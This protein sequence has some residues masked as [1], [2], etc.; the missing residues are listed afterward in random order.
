LEVNDLNIGLATA[1]QNTLG[2]ALCTNNPYGRIIKSGDMSLFYCVYHSFLKMKDSNI[3]ENKT[4]EEGSKR[5][6]KKEIEPDTYYYLIQPL[7]SFFNEPDSKLIITSIQT[8]I[9]ILEKNSQF[10]FKFFEFLFDSL[11]IIKENSDQEVRNCANAFDEFIKDALGNP[12]QGMLSNTFVDEGGPFS[13][14]ILLRKIKD[15]DTHPAVAILVVSW[16]TFLE[17]MP[18]IKLVENLPEIITKLF[19]MLRSKIKDVYQCSEQCLKKLSMGIEFHYDELCNTHKDIVLEILNVIRENCKDST[20]K[21]KICALEWLLMFLSKYNSTI[22]QYLD[23][24]KN[25]CKI[26]EKE[27]KDRK[28]LKLMKKIGLL[29][30]NEIKKEI[31]A[32]EKIKHIPFNLFNTVFDVLFVNIVKCSNKQIE[33]LLMKC[34]NTFQELILTTP[35][36]VIKE[37]ISPL[38]QSIKK[39]ISSTL[40][41]SKIILILEWTLKLFKRF[42]TDI[43]KDIE[44]FIS[45]LTNIIP[46]NNDNVFNHLFFIICEIAKTFPQLNKIIIKEIVKKLMVN[47]T[48]I[49]SYGIDI[50]KK[51]SITIPVTELFENIV[52]EIMIYETDTYFLVSMVNLLD[53]FLLLEDEANEVVT[54]LKNYNKKN[55]TQNEKNFYEKIFNLWSYN[56]VSSIILSLLSE[57]FEL[58]FYLSVK[59]FELNLTKEDYI[60]LNQMVQLLESSVWNQIRIK[61]IQPY[62]Y[63]Y[64]IKALSSILMLLPQGNAYKYLSIRI[65]SVEII[66]AL[67]QDENKKENPNLEISKEKMEEIQSFIKIFL[68]RQ[69]KKLK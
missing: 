34:L 11:I 68:K 18:Y 33:T 63:V 47:L 15:P 64:L 37:K 43:F 6:I 4:G 14:K 7:V 45:R 12:F 2:M 13:I 48:I 29:G 69:E 22:P 62:K 42:K 24:I 56:P 58:S 3:F 30:N 50:L 51:L 25:E 65:K 66:L 60:Q 28:N 39:N 38:G 55:R 9:K 31:R 10:V 61:L 44:D 41:E 46:E 67:D 1:T 21:V 26:K 35:I 19:K 16:L 40:G 23:E 8:I 54:K 36:D 59:M 20:D 17:G 49:S 27:H 53:L 57:N 52:D 32:S 5:I